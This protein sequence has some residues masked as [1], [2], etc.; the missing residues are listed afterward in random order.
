[1]SSSFN[2]SSARSR[3]AQVKATSKW[4][5]EFVADDHGIAGLPSW[6]RL[7]SQTTDGHLVQLATAHGCA[8]A[9]FDARIPDA[10]VIP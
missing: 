2:V 3:L 4:P 7:P 1:L 6:V 9:T 10:L 5:L 8:L